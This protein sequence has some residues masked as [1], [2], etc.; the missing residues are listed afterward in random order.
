[1]DLIVSNVAGHDG[2]ER[3][4]V[5][6]GTRRDIALADLNHTQFVPSRSMMSRSS[7]DGREV[8]L[9]TVST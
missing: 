3:R 4:D 2:I 5:E 6:H 8:A 7:G 9:E 1:V